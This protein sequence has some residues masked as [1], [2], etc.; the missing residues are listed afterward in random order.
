MFVPKDIKNF[1]V[2]VIAGRWKG[3]VGT[4]TN[5]YSDGVYGIDVDEDCNVCTPGKR[6]FGTPEQVKKI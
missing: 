6:A 5:Q 2:K 4:V 3:A 1:R